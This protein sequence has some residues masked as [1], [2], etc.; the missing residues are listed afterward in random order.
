MAKEAEEK[1]IEKAFE[2]HPDDPAKAATVA[3][4]AQDLLL[5]KNAP[6][7]LLTDDEIEAAVDRVSE[8][9]A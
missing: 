3:H 7:A 4:E 8:K 9:L 2:K 5:K 6:G 1:T